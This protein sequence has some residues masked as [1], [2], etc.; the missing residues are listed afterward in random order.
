MIG[1]AVL[2]FTCTAVMEFI[3]SYEVSSV[4]IRH[5]VFTCRRHV[6]QL[7]SGV[8]IVPVSKEHSFGDIVVAKLREV[9]M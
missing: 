9:N 3:A 4:F 6:Y 1:R 5:R 2:H 8:S 7:Q